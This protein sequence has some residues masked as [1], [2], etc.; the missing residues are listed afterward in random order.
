[1]NVPWLLVRMVNVAFRQ[2]V[3]IL[4]E[5]SVVAVLQAAL[6]IHLCVVIQ[7]KLAQMML[8]VLVM[9]FVNMENAPVHHLILVKLVNVSFG[10]FVFIK[11]HFNF[12]LQSF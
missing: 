7:K 4:L 9:L 6:A 3:L 11:N 12:E 1:M 10:C 2:F 8:I 5:A